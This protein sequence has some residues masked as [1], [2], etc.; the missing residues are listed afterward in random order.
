MPELTRRYLV[1]TMATIWAIKV[2]YEVL[3]LP[4]SMPLANWVKRAEGLDAIDDPAT[5]N[6]SPFV[7][8]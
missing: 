8:D 7:V 1:M 5:T 4:V 2:L 6:Y 3:A